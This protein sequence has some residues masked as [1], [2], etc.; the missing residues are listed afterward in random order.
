M[1][2]PSGRFAVF[3]RFFPRTGTPPRH[4]EHMTLLYDLRASPQQNRLDGVSVP[5]LESRPDWSFNAGYPIYP[6]LQPGGSQPYLL[7]DID[8]AVTR[9][10]RGHVPP[11]T[12]S[13]DESRIAFV[14]SQRAEPTWERKLVVVEINDDGRPVSREAIGLPAVSRRAPFREIE[15]VGRSVRLVRGDDDRKLIRI[16]DPD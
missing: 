7:P 6:E 8:E 1:L 10:I 15:F 16:V 4:A 11:Y 9:K 12:W 5:D 3:E 2:S 14:V 13:H